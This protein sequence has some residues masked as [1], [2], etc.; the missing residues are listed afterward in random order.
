MYWYGTVS[1]KSSISFLEKSEHIDKEVWV[2]LFWG[3]DDRQT[4]W[5][6]REGA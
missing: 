1:I 5:C 2:G 6:G 4:A 3:A